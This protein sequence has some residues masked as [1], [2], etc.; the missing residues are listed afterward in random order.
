[1]SLVACAVHRAQMMGVLMQ[2]H[3]TKMLTQ[4]TEMRC[5]TNFFPSQNCSPFS[6]FQHV[7]ENL[8][9]NNKK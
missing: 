2:L 8:G 1:M 5:T 3:S 4:V 7:T 6:A 9:T